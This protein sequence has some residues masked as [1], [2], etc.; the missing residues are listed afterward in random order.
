MED[1][2]KRLKRIVVLI[3]GNGS[4]LQAIIDATHRGG[5]LHDVAHVVLVVSNMNDAYGLI[6]ARQA[7]IPTL[8]TTL[9]TFKDAGRTREAYDRD[10]A[11]RVTTVR[12]D[13]IVLAG[14]MHILSPSF[15]ARFEDIALIN[16]HPALPGAFDG[17][18]AIERAY[19]AY[20]EGIITETGVMVH[21]VIAELDRGEVIVQEKVPIFKEDRLEDLEERIHRVE[22]RLI[23]EG[24][25]RVL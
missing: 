21:R 4:N 16:L 19:H 24:I 18:N 9:K 11:E 3:S 5:F 20:Q 6:R 12:P 23:I 10:L 17:K 25:L 1:T 14:F 13:L 15:L 8:V 2:K 7:A 22:H